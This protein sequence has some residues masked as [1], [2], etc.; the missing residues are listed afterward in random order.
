MRG[1]ARTGQQIAASIA[2]QRA[3]V[4]GRIRHAKGRES[5]FAIVLSSASATIASGVQ[6]G[7]LCPDRSPYGWCSAD[8]LIR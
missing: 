3:E 5:D 2:G 6:I 4:T 7:G 8:V 1:V